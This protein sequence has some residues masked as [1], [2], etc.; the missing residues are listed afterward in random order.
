MIRSRRALPCIEPTNKQVVEGAEERRTFA[1]R[2]WQVCIFAYGQSGTGKTHTMEGNDADPGLAPR[3]M[4]AIFDQMAERT[5]S[6]TWTFECFFSM[7]E[8]HNE[9]I[10]DL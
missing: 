8:I 7:L 5:A 10:R 1:F 4:T 3:A 2:P 6:G 9:A